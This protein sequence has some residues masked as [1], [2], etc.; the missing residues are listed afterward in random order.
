MSKPENKLLLFW[1]HK[2][3]T[4]CSSTPSY[5]RVMSKSNINLDC[6]NLEDFTSKINLIINNPDKSL[7]LVENGIDYLKENHTSEK[8]INKWDK[9]FSSVGLHFSGKQ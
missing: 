3:P 6:K 5:S 1:N 2:I 9:L 4:I 7:K 8:I